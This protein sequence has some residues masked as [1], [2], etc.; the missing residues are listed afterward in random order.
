MFSVQ[1]VRLC[2]VTLTVVM[3]RLTNVSKLNILTLLYGINSV[4]SV[5]I[6]HFQAVNINTDDA[7]IEAVTLEKTYFSCM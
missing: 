5:K 7:L 2:V 3:F 4:P 6:I 1:H